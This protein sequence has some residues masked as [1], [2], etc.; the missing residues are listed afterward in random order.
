M[1]LE[2]LMP[3][4]YAADGYFLDA[5]RR[6]IARLGRRPGQLNG[7]TGHL[8]ESVVELLLDGLGYH[9]LW[10]FT[11]PLS[12]GH[13]VDLVVLSPDGKVLAVEVKATL[14][15]GR[16]PRPAERELVQLSQEW[17]D[18]ADNPG[19]AN[20]ELSGADVYGLVAVVNFADSAWRCAVTADFNTAM[21]ILDPA[22]LAD[23]SWLTAG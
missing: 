19:M 1:V 5:Y 16:W 7:V 10:H 4:K 20:W 22:E 8:G 11:G 6:G 15:S 14:R 18:K 13:G 2:C 9:M 3:A 21:P 17:L 12:G 23:L